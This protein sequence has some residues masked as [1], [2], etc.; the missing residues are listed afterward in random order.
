MCGRLCPAAD[1]NGTRPSAPQSAARLGRGPHS[2]ADNERETV[3]S[4]V[5]TIDPT[6]V[7]LSIDAPF[8]ELKPSVDEAYRESAKQ[9]NV[10]GF[11]RGKVPNRIID[12]RVGRPV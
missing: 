11:R 3:K 1:D 6:R 7:K 2:A 10:P 5:E 8:A 12:Q 4:S 9:V